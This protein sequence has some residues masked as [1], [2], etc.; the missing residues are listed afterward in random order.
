LLRSHRVRTGLSQEDLAGRSGISVRTLRDIERGRVGRP[1]ARSVELLAAALQL[2][3]ADRDRLH[4]AAA[5]TPT[6]GDRRLRI[7]VLGPLEVRR[8]G[9]AMS[10]GATAQRCLLGL[11]ALQPGRTVSRDEITEVLWGSSPPKAYPNLIQV[12]VGRVRRLLEPTSAARTGYRLLVRAEGGYRLDL[13]GDALDLVEFGDLVTRAGQ[14]DADGHPAMAEQLLAQALECWRGPVLGAAEPRLAQHPAAVAAA[15]RRAGAALAYAELAGRAG[16][17]QQAA[18]NLRRVA[19]DEPLHEGLHARLMLALAAA[20]QQ[21][22]A[23]QVYETV[24]GRLNEDLGIEPG[25]DLRAAYVRVLRQQVPATGDDAARPGTD[26]PTAAGTG[27]MSGY[28]PPAQL[29]A[30]VAM[31]T[32]RVTHLQRLDR[33]LAAAPGREVTVSVVD[34]TAGVGK[35]ALVVHWA[36]RVRDRF[37]DGQLYV[38]LRGY[39]AAPPLRPVE[40]LAQAL[41]A[42][43]VPPEQ[44]PVQVEEAAALYR[45]LLAGRRL[46]VVLDNARDA[47]QVRPLLPGSPGCL[48]LV[49]S[50]DRLGGLV[51]RDGATRITLDVLTAEEAGALL[52]RLLGADRVAAEPGATGELAGACAF[53]PLALRIAA[54]NLLDHPRAD[55]A[56]YVAAVRH[57]DALAA[58]EVHGDEQAAVRAAFDLS[59]HRLESDA[60]RMF[61]R[62]GLVP[63]PDVTAEAAAALA[64]TT[65]QQARRLLDR[66]AAAHLVDEHAAGRYTCHD[67]LRRYA[68]ERTGHED[69]E[70]DRHDAVQR[71][72]G[73]YLDTIDAAAALV[74][75]GMV[76]LPPATTRQVPPAAGTAAVEFGGPTAALSWLDAERPNLL[77]AIVH[78]ARHGPRP[79]ACRLADSLR[80]YFQQCMLVVDWLSAARTGL[81]AA[82]ADGDRPAQAAAHLSLG[83]CAWAQGRHRQAVNHHTRMLELA[84]Q[85]GWAEGQAAAL[86]NLGSLY[87]QLGQLDRAVEHLTGSLELNERTGRL[88]GQATSLVNLGTVWTDLGRLDEAVERYRQALVLY[89]RTG[90][91]GGE[92][93]SLANLGEAYLTLG[94]LDRA[95]DHF[96]RALA[97]GRDVGD[98]SVEGEILACIAAVHRDAGRL[99]EA[100]HQADAALST[101]RETG[102]RYT[103]ASALTTLATVHQCLGHPH[104]A[105]DRHQQALRFARDN[106][107]RNLEAQALIGLA[108]AHLQLDQTSPALSCARHALTLTRTVSYRVFEGQALTALAAVHHRLGDHRRAV[109][110]AGQALS[111]HRETGHRL[112]QARTHLLLSHA[113]R[114]VERPDTAAAHWREALELFADIGGP[115]LNER[116]TRLADPACCAASAST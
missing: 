94:Q 14:A 17:H 104:E 45:T 1:R 62:L 91:R 41:R 40:A 82:E 114:H 44:V 42:L 72:Y 24:H 33:L 28:T 35:T 68:A 31:F 21:G 13:D 99:D 102:D 52:T 59:Y 4:A 61:R 29:P 98:R 112:G 15:D 53:L 106:D 18:R 103:E 43:G 66:L 90:S 71:L 16:H 116:R 113:L 100:L 107:C 105:V 75:P 46:L 79:V 67:L 3:A 27:T 48:V 37:A 50:R 70:A 7:G 39:S 58:L 95:L 10:T 83:S 110:H 76:R 23:L 32:G 101:A 63:G 25:A 92:A 2:P 81:A 97:A 26:P 60:R 93:V 74:Y 19:T 22:T 5:E 109:D 12:Y 8:G 88:G 78:T 65:A 34:G 56:G 84:R 64:A 108:L 96:A 73:H 49:T 87:R 115:H 55:V 69:D 77:A 85:A 9:L 47:E 57:S 89:Q 20:G 86:G 30:D 11:L 6:G 51:A 111:V 54:A 36:H 38:N 80:G